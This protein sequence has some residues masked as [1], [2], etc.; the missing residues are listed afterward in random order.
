MFLL[1]CLSLIVSKKNVSPMEIPR[2][3]PRALS[4]KKNG[5]KTSLRGLSPPWKFL[6]VDRYASIMLALDLTLVTRQINVI[7]KTSLLELS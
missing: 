7:I 6:K 4:R 3:F 1:L 5:S 2:D